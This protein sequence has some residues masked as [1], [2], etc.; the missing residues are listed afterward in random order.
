MA[1]TNVQVIHEGTTYYGQIA[2]IK[3]TALSLADHGIFTAYLHTQWKGGGIGVGGLCLDQPIHD[4][5]GKF[6][7]RAGSA[8]GCDHIMKLIETVGAD[9]WEKLPG[10]RLIVLFDRPN[11]LGQV[12]K[13][14][15]GLTNEKVLIFADHAEDW[16]EKEAK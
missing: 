1:E 9:T 10:Q 14:I 13:G 2:E 12:A 7:G 4:T 5:D 6:L 16:T 3:S 8:F 15:A 11:T